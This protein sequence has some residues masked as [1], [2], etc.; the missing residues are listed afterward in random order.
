[1]SRVA[2]PRIDY[3]EAPFERA[4]YPYRLRSGRQTWDLRL[5]AP[6]AEKHPLAKLVGTVSQEALLAQVS[7]RLS[8]E[9]APW[10]VSR[11][12]ASTDFSGE[13]LVGEPI[14]ASGLDLRAIPISGNPFGDEPT[15]PIDEA[16]D[17]AIVA[18]PPC[19]NS[20]LPSRKPTKLRVALCVPQ[21]LLEQAHLLAALERA[22][23]G[24]GL[25]GSENLALLAT[26][27]T[28]I[29]YQC[30]LG[31]TSLLAA[32]EA[33]AQYRMAASMIF[34][35]FLDSGGNLAPHAQASVAAVHDFLALS[36]PELYLLLT[37]AR[38]PGNGREGQRQSRW[39]RPPY[40]AA[41]LEVAL[42]R[43]LADGLLEAIYH[44]PGRFGYS[45]KPAHEILADNP[46]FDLAS[47][48]FFYRRGERLGRDRLA[49]NAGRILG[50]F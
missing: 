8:H 11:C 24:A 14:I 37:E 17:I 28:T 45:W 49:N 19:K 10:L 47:A 7:E 26:P 9:L 2:H 21:D 50:L 18:V 4:A 46:N 23:L 1:M 29:A 20:A 39:P 25:I 12:P 34:E 27:L 44:V 13:S 15:P 48:E 32:Q 16:S 3:I 38:Y 35:S 33:S 31:A 5:V 36:D 22:T 43:L 41:E 6:E 40:E 42:N 30:F